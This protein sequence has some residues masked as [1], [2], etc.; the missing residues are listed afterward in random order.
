MT[1][2][3]AKFDDHWRH[4]YSKNYPTKFTS[5]S[6]EDLYCLADATIE[7]SGGINAIVG[8]NGVGKS[9]LVASI[10]QLLASNPN[11][12]EEVYTQ[13]L[14]GSTIRGTAISDGTELHLSVQNGDS[15]W[16]I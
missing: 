5:I 13:R 7:F 6:F 3:Q 4:V 10:A 14:W 2:R 15:V 12:V 9:T 11:A 1:L 8:G 16:R